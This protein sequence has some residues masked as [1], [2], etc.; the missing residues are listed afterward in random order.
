[1]DIV[2]QKP[3]CPCKRI[4]CERFGDCAACKEHHHNSERNTL[5]AC[6]RLKKKKERKNRRK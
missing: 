4:K 6:E 3:S 5:T 2:K 1:M